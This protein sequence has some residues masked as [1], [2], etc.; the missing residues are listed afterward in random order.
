MLRKNYY[1][2]RHHRIIFFQWIIL[3][4]AFWCAPLIVRGDHNIDSPQRVLQSA[5]ELDYPPFALVGP[6]GGA[7]GFSVDLLRAVTQAVGLEVQITVGPWHKIKERLER[8]ELDLLPLVSYSKARDQVFDF[9]APYLRM[10]GAIFVRQGEAAIQNASDLKGKEVLVMRGDTAHEFVLRNRLTDKLILT[11][12]FGE[13]MRR[14]SAGQHD[15][16]VVQHLVGLGLI[17]RLGLENLVSVSPFQDYSLKPEA[18]PM[19]GF[20]QKFCM[21]VAEGNDDLLALLNEGLAIVNAD[22]TYERLY[23]QWFGP[24]IPQPSAPWQSVF[25]YLYF[26]LVPLVLIV[27]AAGLRYIKREIEMSRELRRNNQLLD[28]IRRAQSKFISDV[29]M[30]ILFDELLN[31]LLALTQSAYGFIGEIRYLPNQAPFLKTYA[32]TEIACDQIASDLI[33]PGDFESMAFYNLDTLFG[34]VIKTAR[35]VIAN[36][37]RTDLRSAGLPKGHPPLDAFLGLPIFSGETMVGMV[38]I[39]NRPNGYDENLV[40]FLQPFLQTCGHII[41][42]FRND[43]QRKQAVRNLQKSQTL[44]Q[45]VFDGIQDPL[46]MLDQ[47]MQIQV[48]NHAAKAYF[49]ITEDQDVIGLPCHQVFKGDAQPCDICTIPERFEDGASINFKRKGFM[50]PDRRE[51]VFVYPLQNDANQTNAVILHIIDIT[52]EMHLQK[53]IL[54]SEKLASVGE[55]AA[56]LAHEVNNP[57][58]GIINYAQ[59]LM[60]EDGEGANIPQKILQEGERVAA[61]I[62]NLLSF[63]RET[64]DRMRPASLSTIIADALALVNQQFQKEGVH[65][66]L[67]VPDHLPEVQ[68]NRQKIQQVC[69]NLLSNARYALN[70]KYPRP[71]PNKRLSIESKIE[72]NGGETY[73]RTIFKD[74][75][76]GVADTSLDRLCDPFFT[77]KPEGEG[78]GLGL[79]I[80]YGIIKEHGGRLS[81]ESEPGKYTNVFVDLPIRSGLC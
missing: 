5:S 18:R 61:I 74:T 20:E 43:Q 1:I 24:L 78:A 41:Q 81:F 57:I 3:I 68:V 21:A 44:L 56:G 50:D 58:N 54:Q 38:G 73:V 47:G 11:D 31:D 80:S 8:K 9:T 52:E 48:L 64:D 79:S 77:T 25:K 32:F 63:A 28:A 30:R 75:G 69:L 67:N 26:I 12:S 17:K 60:D 59:I 23:N 7:H 49:H 45:G 62:Q 33:E 13:A 19:S 40:A 34:A 66:T 15:A 39:A 76:V 22:G 36:E 35:P 14:L 42:S 10:H 27:T 71:D 51:H 72:E 46:I 2:L 6:D 29:D 55:L 65:L 70:Q 16:V 53:Q 37:P 4:T